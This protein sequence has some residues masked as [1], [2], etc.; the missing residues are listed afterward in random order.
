MTVIQ[1]TLSHKYTCTTQP[2]LTL[3]C[4][5]HFSADDI[6]KYFSYF[7][8]KIGFDILC[9]LTSMETICMKC[10]ILLSEKNKKIY[11]SSAELAQGCQILFTYFV[12]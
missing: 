7:P 8:Q 2:H 4:W 11:L 1:V 12:V 3:S 5:V 10:Q 9:K 6:L